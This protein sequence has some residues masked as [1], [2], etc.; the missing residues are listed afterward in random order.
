MEAEAVGGKGYTAR[1]SCNIEGYIV[2][3]KRKKWDT[4]P[5]VE[6]Q[7]TI[8]YYKTMKK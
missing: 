1:H 8:Y 2:Q 6:K 3:L 5:S 7:T 4:H